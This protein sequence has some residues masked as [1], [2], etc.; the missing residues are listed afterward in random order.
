VGRLKGQRWPELRAW[1]AKTGT[2]QA[3]LSAL[4]GVSQ[5]QVCRVLGGTRAFGVDTA[6]RLE[7]LTDIPLEKFL[8]ART[9]RTLKLLSVHQA[10]IKRTRPVTDV[11]T[12]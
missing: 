3:E 1:M 10:R 12:D 6:M 8:S 2:S 11:D 5:A 4:L 9:V 7:M